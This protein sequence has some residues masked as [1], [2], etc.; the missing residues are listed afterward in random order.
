MEHEK[1]RLF[2]WKRQDKYIQVRFLT[3]KSLYFLSKTLIDDKQYGPFLGIKWKAIFKREL[4]FRKEFE[5]ADKV[6]FNLLLKKSDENS[7]RNILYILNPDLSVKTITKLAKELT[8]KYK[9]TNVVEE[10]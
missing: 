6:F 1:N 10:M 8:L 3:N 9:E 5:L 7:K 2:Y 4:E